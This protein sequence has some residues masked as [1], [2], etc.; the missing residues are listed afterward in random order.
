MLKVR[1]AAAVSIVST[2]MRTAIKR[3]SR[4]GWAKRSV[5]PVPRMSTSGRASITASKCASLRSS[6]VLT[7]HP[8][9]APV[10]GTR[11][12]RVWA[13]PFTDTLLRV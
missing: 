4:P 5:G 2:P 8:M 7:G 3:R 10:G 13:S 9:T 12:L 11:M 6:R 1:Q